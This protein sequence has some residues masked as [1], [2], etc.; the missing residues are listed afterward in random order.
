[1]T[2][3]ATG[4]AAGLLAR[5][6]TEYPDAWPETAR[7]L[8]VHHADWTQSQMDLYLNGDE[9]TQA[10]KR[11][12][13]RICGY[14][15]PNQQR[16]LHDLRNKVSL[17][18]QETLQPFR[19]NG[20]AGAMNEMCIFQLPWPVQMLERLENAQVKLRITLS[21]FVE[22]SPSNRGWANRYRY[23]SHGLRFDLRRLNE[24]AKEFNARVNV[25]VRSEAETVDA[26]TDEGWLLGH[27]LRG[28]GSVHSDQ[29]EG[30][31][32]NL[33]SRDLIAIYPVMG[34][35]RQRLSLGRCMSQARFSLIVSL[36]SEDVDLDLYT[37]L[38]N[39]LKVP[40]D[41]DL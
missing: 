34:W 3:A 11:R 2:S 32:V 24:S 8:T 20:S 1:M 14:G 15:V 33:A 6:Y 39:Q 5:I 40:L 18:A 17:I 38:E 37:A 9:T 26:P 41:L 19:L 13:L 23:A 21:Y 10:E 22:P 30:P 12:L 28:Y 31:A 7:G 16:V 29:W 25:A 36:E 27:K 4:Q 35:W